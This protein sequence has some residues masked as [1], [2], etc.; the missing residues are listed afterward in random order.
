MFSENREKYIGMAEAVS[1]IGLMLG[2]VIGG[3]IYTLTTYFWCF[4]FFA[5][6]LFLS[7][8]FTFF[9]APNTLN[10]SLEAPEGEE[11]EGN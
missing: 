7:A 8:L 11:G 2:P 1:G 3:G 10:Q 4:F 6:V 5:F 9:A